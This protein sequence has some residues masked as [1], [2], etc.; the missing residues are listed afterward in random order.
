MGAYSQISPA[1]PLGILPGSVCATQGKCYHFQLPV[2]AQQFGYLRRAVGHVN[3]PHYMYVQDI[4]VPV[5]LLAF[6]GPWVYPP[7]LGKAEQALYHRR[8]PV[9]CTH[10]LEQ[11]IPWVS[12]YNFIIL[13]TD[14][15]ATSGRHLETVHFHQAHGYKL[16]A[17][18]G[19][20]MAHKVSGHHRQQLQVVHLAPAHYRSWGPPATS[21]PGRRPRLDWACGRPNVGVEFACTTT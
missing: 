7:L 2:S 1:C 3:V 11:A 21:G 9:I 5:D 14:G 15:G 13:P 8:W 18:V 4:T 20:I 19:A 12:I 6:P 10:Q 16:N 17:S